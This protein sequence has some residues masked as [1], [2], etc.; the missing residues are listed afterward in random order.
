PP[1]PT[2]ARA[3][4]A[5]LGT[6]KQADPDDERDRWRPYP[7]PAPD[8]RLEIRERRGAGVSATRRTGDDAA[9][10]HSRRRRVPARAPPRSELAIGEA[11]DPAACGR[12]RAT[13]PRQPRRP[14]PSPR[15][16]VTRDGRPRTPR[17]TPPRQRR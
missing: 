4:P 11:K 5:G 17:R 12:E 10:P 3:H 16:P 2:G 14:R 1:A 6:G 13:P 9:V 15:E 7:G 8:R